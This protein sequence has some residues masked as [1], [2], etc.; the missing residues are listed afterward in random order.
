MSKSKHYLNSNGEPYDFLLY[1][2]TRPNLRDY[3]NQ[4]KM[5]MGQHIIYNL[6]DTLKVDGET[7]SFHIEY[8]ERWTNILELRA[9]PERIP[10]LYPNIERVSITTHSVYIIQCV[11]KEHIAIMD[12]P[13]DYPEKNVAD[14]TTRC[15]PSRQDCKGL[16]V[17]TNS[18]FKK[19]Y[20]QT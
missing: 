19:I 3:E 16:Y 1:V 2:Y 4:M 13:D 9:L 17:V 14:I 8:P 11:H 12:N 6:F 20:G 18:S 5:C 15:C 7:K 10:K